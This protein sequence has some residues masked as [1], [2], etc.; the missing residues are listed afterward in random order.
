MQVSRRQAAS[1]AIVVLV[2]AAF[3][4][5]TAVA[6]NWSRFRGENGSGISEQKGI[7][8]TWSPG[9]YAWNIELP[10]LGHAAPVIWDDKLFVTT[11]VDEG[12]LRYLYCLNADTGEEIWSRLVGMNKSHK[13]N[14]SS[15]ASSTPCTDGETVYVSFADEEHYY[16]GAYDFDG[17]LIWRR[18]LGDFESQHGL[19]VSPILFEDMLIVANDQDGPSSVVALDKKTGHTRWSTLR[20]IQRVSYSTPI[21]LQEAGEEPQLIVTSGAM[22]ITSL[23]PY[24]GRLNWQSGEFPLRTVASPVY[25]EGLLIASCGQGGRYGVLQIAV[26]PR[27]TGDV[28]GSHIKWERKTVIPYVPTPIVYGGH[29]YE[30]ND[31]GTAACVEIKT[32]ETLSK[33]RIGGNYSGSPIC[34]DGKLYCIS[35]DGEV[36]VLSASPELEV[37]GKTSLGDA[38]HSTPSIANGKLYLRTFHRLA[39]LA[40]RE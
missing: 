8:T 27:G 39:C 33:K 32:G 16:V 11:A 28:S 25:A 4:T 22:G 31:E 20:S 12:A 34:I 37:L 21:V 36:V 19:G 6:Q 24:T 13:H 35:E 40:T 3:C 30:W 15:W 14:K 2:A 5:Q 9:D 26:D 18:N 1:V 29:L 10:G 7:P 17:D 38:S 23:N